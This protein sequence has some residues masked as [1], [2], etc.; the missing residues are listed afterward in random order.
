MIE[1]VMVVTQE[2][3]MVEEVVME[4]VMMEVWKRQRWW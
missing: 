3:M 4:E 2:I 1:V